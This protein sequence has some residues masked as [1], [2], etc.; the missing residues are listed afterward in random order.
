[1][2]DKCL[3]MSSTR[4]VRILPSLMSIDSTHIPCILNVSALDC[5]LHMSVREGEDNAE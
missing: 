5:G 1:M 3:M 2:I 4:F